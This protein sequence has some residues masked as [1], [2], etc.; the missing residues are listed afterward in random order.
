MK[1]KINLKINGNKNVKYITVKLFPNQQ[2]KVMN[3]LNSSNMNKTNIIPMIKPKL[4]NRRMNDRHKKKE[5]QLEKN[6]IFSFFFGRKWKTTT[7][8]AK[9]Y[10]IFNLI[11]CTAENLYAQDFH[12]YTYTYYMQPPQ[13]RFNFNTFMCSKNHL[14][15][16]FWFWFVFYSLFAFPQCFLCVFFSSIVLFFIISFRLFL[17]F[18]SI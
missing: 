14:A 9:L 18:S 6:I 12:L 1:I 7:T 8:N 15:P 16:S 11:L 10:V 17:S 4:L 3:G 13:L 2:S 5:M